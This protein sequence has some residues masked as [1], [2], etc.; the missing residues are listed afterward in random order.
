M[1]SC[2]IQKNHHHL[3]ENLFFFIGIIF[4]L[5]S[6]T[7]AEAYDLMLQWDANSEP[8]VAGYVLYIDDGTSDPTYEYFDTYPLEDIDPDNPSCII[9]GLQNDHVYY[10][11]LT[12]YDTEGNESDL[13]DDI[14]VNNGM[15][16]ASTL[17]TGGSSA[18]ASSGG[19][20]GGCFI[21][22]SVHNTPHHGTFITWLSFA[23]AFSILIASILRLLTKKKLSEM[24]AANRLTTRKRQT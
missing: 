9:T 4:F 20:G 3:S 23:F 14:C 21:S 5:L 6:I 13:S 10:F 15:E 2:G 11:A 12:A 17:N 22:S 1:K 8:D 18:T 16:C 7:P 24:K 19:G